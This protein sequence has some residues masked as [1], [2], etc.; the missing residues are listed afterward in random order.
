MAH[1]AK[2]NSSN[3]VEQVVVVDN[4]I[5]TS[6]EAG[7]TFLKS[8]YGQNTEW[9]QGS[10]NTRH[11]VHSEGGTP[12]RMN[13][14]SVGWLYRADLDAFCPPE[15]IKYFPSWVFDETICDFVAPIAA[16]VV[17]TE[18]YRWHEPSLSWKHIDEWIANNL[19][20]NLN[21]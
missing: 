21:N 16:P 3:I 12:L 17:D 6:E 2:L 10:Y 1:F 14:P 4:S 15:S 5:A 19:T 13:F 9:K 8:L 7:I 11:G 18:N 20:N